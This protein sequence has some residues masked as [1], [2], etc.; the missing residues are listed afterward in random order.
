MRTRYIFDRPFN[1]VEGT[2]SDNSETLKRIWLGSFQI[3]ACK[4]LNRNN[5]SYHSLRTY[6]SLDPQTHSSCKLDR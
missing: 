5:I 4:P 3:P 2:H 6:T 1:S